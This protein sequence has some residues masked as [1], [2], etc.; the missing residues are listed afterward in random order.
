M[1]KLTYY[2]NFEDLKTDKVHKSQHQ[3]ASAK[4]AEMKELLALISAHRRSKDY[5][6]SRQSSKPSGNGK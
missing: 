4:E 1:A 5:P 3:S 2:T 6:S